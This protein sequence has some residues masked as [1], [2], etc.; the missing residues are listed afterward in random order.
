[1]RFFI[2]FAALIFFGVCASGQTFVTEHVDAP[3]TDNDGVW[4]IGYS[5]GTFDANQSSIESLPWWGNEG[6]AQSFATAMDVNN[7]QFAFQEVT[8]TTPDYA[9]FST[10]ST[11]V[12][13]YGNL[14]TSSTAIYAISAQNVPAPLPILGILPVVGFLKRM[15]KR[16]RA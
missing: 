3:G 16:Q 12:G 5:T 4:R 8:F 15:R 7:L 9:L 13:S 1:M 14:D 6:A 10:N 2:T 11:S